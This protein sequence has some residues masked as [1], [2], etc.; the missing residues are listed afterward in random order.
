[1]ITESFDPNPT[2][3]I[4]PS[5]FAKPV[6]GMPKVAVTCFSHTLFSRLAAVTVRVPDTCRVRDAEL[7]VTPP[8]DSTCF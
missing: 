4:L 3:V 8:P 7:Q 2:G 1:M 5:F 6:P